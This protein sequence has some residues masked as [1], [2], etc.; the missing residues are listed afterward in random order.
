MPMLNWMGRE[1]AVRYAKEVVQKILRENRELSYGTGNNILVH[2]DNL[3]ALKAL[4]PFYAG[5]VKCI[6][7]ERCWERRTNWPHSTSTSSGEGY[8]WLSRKT[9]NK[10]AP[11]I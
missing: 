3:E 10:R 8:R 6:Y 7:L 1:K 11:P 2:G 9:A 5:E 4:L